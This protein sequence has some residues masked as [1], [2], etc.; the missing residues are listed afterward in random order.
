MEQLAQSSKRHASELIEYAELD[1]EGG[2]YTRAFLKSCS[3]I[4]LIVDAMLIAKGCYI[5]S[6]RRL[7]NIANLRFPWLRDIQKRLDQFAADPDKKI[8]ERK[9]ARAALMEGKWL[10]EQAQNFD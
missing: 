2:D 10:L 9:D 3:A 8:I 5:P 6:V 1:F 4:R 7:T